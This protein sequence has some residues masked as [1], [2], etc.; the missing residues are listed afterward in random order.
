MSEPTIT[1]KFLTLAQ[2]K[3]QAHIEADFNDEDS[4]LM[5]LGAAA[6][7]KVFKDTQR[8]YDEL[9]EMEGEWPYDLT[10]AGLMLTSQWYKY[11]E[12]VDNQ[13][14]SN[15]PYGYE[16]LYMPYRKGTYSSVREEDTV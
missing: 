2:I 3:E 15:V 16:V 1:L 7:R 10:L 13:S 11:R 9:V 12:A 4:Y 5:L 8:S 14:M 6:E